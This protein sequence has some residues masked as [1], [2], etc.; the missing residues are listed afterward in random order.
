M[1][2]R[3]EAVSLLLEDTPVPDHLSMTDPTP[4]RLHA[5]KSHC[6]GMDHVAGGA[7]GIGLRCTPGIPVFPGRHGNA[8]ANAEPGGGK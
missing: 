2:P 4:V 3:D 6:V 8:A 5:I 7:S 1:F